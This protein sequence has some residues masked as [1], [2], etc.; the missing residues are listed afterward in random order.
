MSKE[1]LNKLHNALAKKNIPHEF[2]QED[3][4]TCVKIPTNN[5]QPF[6]IEEYYNTD[7]DCPIFVTQTPTKVSEYVI[8]KEEDF[9]QY[10]HWLEFF[11]G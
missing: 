3:H 11:F 1:Y 5:S 10:V 7:L 6:I 4:L 8:D 9:N 2:I